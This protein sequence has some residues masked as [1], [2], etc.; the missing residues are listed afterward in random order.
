MLWTDKY[1]P[2]TLDEVVGNN[3]E[4]KIILDW[5]NNWKKG[6]PQQPLLLVGP[7]GIGKTTLAL[8]IAKEFSE[9]I[10]IPVRTLED[11]EAG[12][13]TPPEYIPRLISYQLKYEEL[14]QK[15]NDD[16]AE[17]G[18]NALERL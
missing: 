1:R 18:E 5:V 16:E 2:Q 11:W 15:V 17:R 12:R 4:K 7:P 3:K 9:H 6:N 10:G 8:V 13:R 14:L